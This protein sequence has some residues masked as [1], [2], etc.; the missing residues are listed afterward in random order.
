MSF[1]GPFDTAVEGS[2][3]R[4]GWTSAGAWIGLRAADWAEAGIGGAAVTP[5]DVFVGCFKT[6]AKP[7]ALVEGLG[8]TWSVANGYHKIFACCGY[9]H[10]AVEATWNCSAA[11]RS[12]RSTTS[13]DRGRDGAGGRP[14]DVEPETCSLRN[15]PFPTRSR[16]RATGHGRGAAFHVRT[17]QERTSR[18]SGGG[19]ASP[20]IRLQPWPKDRP[21]A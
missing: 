14:E 6:G 8:N 4:N 2:L 13:R 15:F 21:R 16:R 18:T 17:L 20:P 9:S 7:Q 1:A 5:Y 12:A 19:C 11:C 10:S 3:V